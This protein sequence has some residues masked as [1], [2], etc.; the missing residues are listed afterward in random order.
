MGRRNKV[1]GFVLAVGLV[2][3]TAAPASGAT[4]RFASPGGSGTACTQA[5]PCDIVTAVN[6]ASEGDDVTIGPG[7]YGSPTP[8]TQELEDEGETMSIHGQAGAPRPVIVSSAAYALELDGLKSSLS[9][10]DVEDAEGAYG[11]YVAGEEVTVDHVISHASTEGAVACYPRGTITDSVCWADGPNGIAATLLIAI[12]ASATLRNDTLIASGPGGVAVIAKAQSPTS[13]SLTLSNTIARGAG[14]D[15]VAVT[16]SDPTSAAT[17]TADHSNYSTVKIENGGGGSTT[18]VTPAGSGTNQTGAPLFVDAAAGNFREL[19]GSVATIDRGENSA[20]D[21]IADLDGNARALPGTLGCDATPRAMTDIGAYE[22]VPD[23]LRCVS[24]L[25]PAATVKVKVKDKVNR[26]AGKITFSFSATGTIT[27]FQCR[28]QRLAAKKGRK[29][30]RKAVFSA[31]SSPKAYKHLRPGRY[32]FDVRALDAAGAPAATATGIVP[33][34][35]PP[36]R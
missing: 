24:P 16:G 29:H 14:S 32:R 7:T 20:L 10:V 15:I 12:P 13:M 35:P 31:C 26:R 17:V 18:S 6:G 27:S 2:F 11:L 22:H 3:L 8:L 28:F 23:V 19:P 4:A 5:Q 25:L 33:L 34:K 1:A 21:G 36:R 30:R 9:N